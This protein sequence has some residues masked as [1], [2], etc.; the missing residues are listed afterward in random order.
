MRCQ[1]MDIFTIRKLLQTHNIFELPLRVTYYTRVSTD[2]DE[3]INSLEN[4]VNYYENYIKKNK[5]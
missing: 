4:Q 1:T 5:N 2:S 3:Q